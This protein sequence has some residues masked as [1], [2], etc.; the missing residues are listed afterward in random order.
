[1]NRCLSILRTRAFSFALGALL[2]CSALS[3]VS[4]ANPVA[5]TYNGT[6]Y[7]VTFELLNSY[8]DDSARLSSQVWVNDSNAA[9]YF[10][11]QVGA[12]LGLGNF[13]F[14]GPYFVF[15]DT[16]SAWL[17]NFYAAH[18]PSANISNVDG[19][20]NIYQYNPTSDSGFAGRFAY[21]ESSSPVTPP[22]SVPDAGATYGL[23]LVA[24]TTLGVA[25][26]RLQSVAA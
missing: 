3:Q 5:V 19:Y 14:E 21:V 25:R 6:V 1:M 9:A 23:M 12:S 24:L 11:S 18:D 16:G 13:G 15:S 7:D 17:G 22:D 8:N 2:A 10:A 4:R 20:A 26:R